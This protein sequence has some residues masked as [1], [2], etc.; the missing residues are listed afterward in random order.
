[1]NN[2]KKLLRPLASRRALFDYINDFDSMGPKP[3]Y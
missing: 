2:G 1:M 3:I